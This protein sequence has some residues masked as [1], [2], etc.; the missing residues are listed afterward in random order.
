MPKPKIDAKEARDAIRSGMDDSAL[1]A[2]Y[3]LSPRGLQSLFKKLI[4]AG[5]IKKEELAQR[6]PN[7]S[8]SVMLAGVPISEPPSF[9]SKQET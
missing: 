2:K 7:H 6:M 8:K 5:A 3:N 1:M 9:D 4:E